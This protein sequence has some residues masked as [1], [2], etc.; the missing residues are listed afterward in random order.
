MVHTLKEFFVE[1]LLFIPQS[2][3]YYV[4]DEELCLWKHFNLEELTY[5]CLVK[6]AD[7]NWCFNTIQQGIK[8]ASAHAVCSLEKLQ[9][10]FINRSLIGFKNKVWNLKKQQFENLSKDH[11]LFSTLSLNYENV[12]AKN[13]IQI[14]PK[15]CQWLLA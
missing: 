14:A 8:S 12:N 6:F 4:F 10:I 15:I 9:Q 3:D 1:N 7:R 13:I 5:F 11:Y 2:H